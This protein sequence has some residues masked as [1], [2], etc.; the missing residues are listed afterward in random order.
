MGCFK[1]LLTIARYCSPL[2]RR[3]LSSRQ[4]AQVLAADAMMN[5]H[6]RAANSREKAFGLIGAGIALS[7]GERVIDPLGKEPCVQRIPAGRLVS[8]YRASARYAVRYRRNGRVFRRDDKRERSA[9]ALAH[10]NY[11]APLVRTID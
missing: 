7:I 2:L 6:L 3:R 11:N 10:D 4:G 1:A 9:A 8:K 5:A